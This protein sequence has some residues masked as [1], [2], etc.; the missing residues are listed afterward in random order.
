MV[1]V[2]E[3][4][5][6]TIDAVCQSVFKDCVTQ[7]IGTLEVLPLIIAVYGKADHMHPLAEAC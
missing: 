7:K 6:H 1:R 2:A 5:L 3:A 4:L